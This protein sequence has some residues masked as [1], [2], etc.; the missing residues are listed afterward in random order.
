MFDLQAGE[1][2][3]FLACEFRSLL[4]SLQNLSGMIELDLLREKMNCSRMFELQSKLNI[5]TAIE[6]I[7]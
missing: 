5:P 4:C 3:E 2:I 7:N 6:Q 1:E